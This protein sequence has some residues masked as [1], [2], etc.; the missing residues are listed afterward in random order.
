MSHQGI[1]GIPAPA[2]GKDHTRNYKREK[3]LNELEGLEKLKKLDPNLYSLVKLLSGFKV[4][5]EIGE[6]L[7]QISKNIENRLRSLPN[8]LNPDELLQIT[9][10][11]VIKEIPEE[12]KQQIGSKKGIE[13][14]MN[15]VSL[16]IDISFTSLTLA[17]IKKE[18]EKIASTTPEKKEAIQQLSQIHA[19]IQ[20]EKSKIIKKFIDLFSKYLFLKEPETTSPFVNGLAPLA[21]SA[22][23]FGAIRAFLRPKDWK[24]DDEGRPCFIHAINGEKL[25]GKFA[26]QVIIP[27]DVSPELIQKELAWDLVNQLGIDTA[28]IHLLL[29]SYAAVTTRE[30]KTFCIPREE[31]YRCLGLDKRTD[32]TRK[33][34]DK[35]CLQILNQL[36]SI[37][38]QILHLELTGKTQK[39]GREVKTFNY[40]GGVYPVWDI[41]LNKFGQGTFDVKDGKI[42]YDYKDWQV[43]GREGIWGDIF[44]HG[45]SSMRQFGYLA[46]EM[47]EKVER[48]HDSM[49]AA[50]AVLLTFKNRFVW[51]KNFEISNQEIIEFSGREIYPEDKRRRGEI[52]NQVI[53]AILEQEKWGWQINFNSWPEYLKSQI[54]QQAARSKKEYWD[55]FLNCRTLFIPPLPL[56]E[57]S[58]NIKYLPPT[59]EKTKVTKI[60]AWTGEEIRELRQSLGWTSKQ[61]ADYLGIS[62]SMMS[63]ME[64]N[65]RAV[66]PEYKKKFQ[67]LE[68][69]KE[70]EKPS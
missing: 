41:Y 29:L 68:K 58:Q 55:E 42:T 65:K 9:N 5:G 12:I 49:S 26:Y 69:K 13:S 70:N 53:N 21:C 60:K 31:V 56:K 57:A 20:K 16:Y 50:L 39:N 28:W 66:K 48:K 34:K 63:R 33:E 7:E 52:K 2:A 38:M 25:K 14:L 44:L 46:R 23:A 30:N 59:S 62:I 35:K 11:I 32:L 8:N 18:I 27:Q 43:V 67:F 22:P 36:Q 54:N 4:S 47:L 17:K 19:E 24:E 1:R 15:I 6:T 3:T 64:S 10:S 51:G 45:E 40:Q 37:G 61:L